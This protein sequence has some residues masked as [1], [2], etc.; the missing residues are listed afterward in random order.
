MRAEDGVLKSLKLGEE[1]VI[2][3]IVKKN[4]KQS[5]YLS[6]MLH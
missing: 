5:T 1:R 2:D 6:T 3:I 4:L